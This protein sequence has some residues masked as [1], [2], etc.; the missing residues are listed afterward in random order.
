MTQTARVYG[1]SLYDLAAEEQLTDNIKQ[2]MADILQLFREHPDY[3]RLLSEP[4]IPTGERT[5][6][7]DKAFGEQA[8][9]YL[10][11]FLKLLCERSILA[12]F[13]G[14]CEEFTRRY[15]V[16]HNIAEAVVTSAAGL[17]EDQLSA[18]KA[19][20]EKISG[21]HISLIQRVD[22]S[23]LGGLRVEL[24]GKQLDGTVQGRLSGISRKLNEV[25][26]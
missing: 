24:E 19:K 13:A 25:I 17:S 7:I 8:E 18:L 14:C 23:A 20:L 15:N 11:S 26:V 5:G 12:E 6:L 16:D 2:Q 1:G 21:K 22:S 10:V 4:S 3:I 9:K